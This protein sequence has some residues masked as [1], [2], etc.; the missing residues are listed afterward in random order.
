M[1][2]IRDFYNTK[3]I[4]GLPGFQRKFSWTKKSKVEDFW[5]SI[6]NQYAI[7]R[8]FTWDFQGRFENVI[9]LHKF[10]QAFNARTALPT[11]LF[12]QE[13]LDEKNEELRAVCDGQQRLT[14]ILIGLCGYNFGNS[15][16]SHVEKYLYWDLLANPDIN[17]ADGN[18]RFQFLD[19]ALVERQNNIR[20]NDGKRTFAWVKIQD[21][22]E[23][24]CHSE[25]M[26]AAGET[27]NFD[28]DSTGKWIHFLGPAKTGLLDG[29]LDGDSVAEVIHA[30]N[31][32]V[33]L[34]LDSV[35]AKFALKNLNILWRQIDEAD[36][37]LDFH[38]ISESVKRFEDNDPTSWSW[39]I[40]KAVQFFVRING[41]GK[42]LDPNE[43]LF[44]M[45]AKN[46][47]AEQFGEGIDLK[48]D[49][50]D[51]INNYSKNT[52]NALLNYTIEYKN[53]LRVCL[54][55][56]TNNVLFKLKSFDEENCQ[57]ILEEW[58]HIKSA[59]KS[60]FA[61]MKHM[62][63]GAYVNSFNALIPVFF[64]FYKKGITDPLV[65]LSSAENLELLKYFISA[66]ESKDFGSHA[67][68]LLQSLKNSQQTLYA[69]VDYEFSFDD[70]RSDLPPDKS[71][72]ISDSLI[73]SMLECKMNHPLIYPLFFL[74]NGFELAESNLEVSWLYLDEICK[75]PENILVAQYNC[76][77]HEIKFI[78]RNYLKVA[79][80]MVLKTEGILNRNN[81]M[82]NRW[83]EETIAARNFNYIFGKM[84]VI[85]FLEFE[86]I[87]V[88]AE[89]T[90]TNYLQMR[91]FEEVYNNR[92]AYLKGLI[93]GF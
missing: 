74:L 88:P 90:S 13:E 11:V 76:G 77:Q 84:R 69:D 39:D 36:D 51:L 83:L 25:F 34:E 57:S 21:F 27:L 54:Y 49:F 10:S 29:L 35:E 71:L 16:N 75:Q 18:K 62:K 6:F 60:T 79:N 82:L 61:Y 2:S 87:N 48:S 19:Q 31:C 17:N 41:G 56:V 50:D 23:W 67:D 68:N 3:E 78:H 55:L 20:N 52:P 15:A 38:D 58:P 37:Y 85:D 93:Q 65:E 7:P 89:K 12:S 45:L 26:N 9:T 1:A 53:I 70:L 59:M 81:R 47:D 42:A 24:A 30:I 22:F 66:V 44:A 92:K 32:G 86:F 63:L 40:D 64:H 14:S 4:Y 8:F 73:D 80:L 72:A 91:N 43:L 28:G 5:D 33:V 46:A